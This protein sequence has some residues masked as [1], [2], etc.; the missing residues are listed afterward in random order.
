VEAAIHREFDRIVAIR[1][2]RL[3]KAEMQRGF[4]DMHDFINRRFDPLEAAFADL[5][6]PLAVEMLKKTR[7]EAAKQRP[8]D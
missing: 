8:P 6:G 3:T 7:E 4:D 2:D 5:F 1:A